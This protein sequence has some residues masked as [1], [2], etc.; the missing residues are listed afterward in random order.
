MDKGKFFLTDNDLKYIAL[1][2]NKLILNNELKEFIR[3]SKKEVQKARQRRTTIAAA[4]GCCSD[5][6]F[7]RIYISGL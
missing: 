4:A 3:I 1:Y 5:N 7:V 6:Y 2:E